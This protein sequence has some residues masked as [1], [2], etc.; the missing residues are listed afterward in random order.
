MAEEGSLHKRI[1]YNAVDDLLSFT[2]IVQEINTHL[3]YIKS[4]V[5][6]YSDNN[7]VELVALQNSLRNIADYLKKCEACMRSLLI[8]IKHNKYILFIHLIFHIIFLNLNV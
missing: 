6:M 8:H 2:T 7:N 1:K 3:Q 5:D 4:Y